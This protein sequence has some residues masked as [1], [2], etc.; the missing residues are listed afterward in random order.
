MRCNRTPP[1]EADCPWTTIVTADIK[2]QQGLTRH[3]DHNVTADGKLR[4]R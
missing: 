3:D 1:P 4:R 2:H